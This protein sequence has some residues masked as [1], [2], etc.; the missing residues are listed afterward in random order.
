MC[1]Y[2]LFFSARWDHTLLCSLLFSFLWC[3]HFIVSVP[4]V[5]RQLCSTPGE[6]KPHEAGEGAGQWQQD[7]SNT[8][9]GPAIG[10][11][12]LRGGADRGSGSH[13]PLTRR[14]QVNSA[15]SPPPRG[16]LRGGVPRPQM[17]PCPLMN[18][19]CLRRCVCSHDCP[20]PRL[21]ERTRPQSGELTSGMFCK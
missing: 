20:D 19:L 5:L 16:H 11:E 9:L 6:R 7:R 10:P 21:G 17:A 2:T 18:A 1:L 14:M 4:E 15:A 8:G 12:T 3:G 13:V